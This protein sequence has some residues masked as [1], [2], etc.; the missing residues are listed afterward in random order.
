MF[1]VTEYYLVHD[2]IAESVTEKINELIRL[3]WQ[4][5]GGVSMIN[6][7]YAQA[8]VKYGKQMDE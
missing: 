6:G 4:P 2:Q 8:M 7:H 3:G 5:F 1:E